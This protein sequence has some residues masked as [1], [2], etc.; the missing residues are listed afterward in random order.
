MGKIF[1]NKTTNTISINDAN[2]L[3]L[4]TTHTVALACTCATRSKRSRG[5]APTQIYNCL[6]RCAAQTKYSAPVLMCQRCVCMYVSVHHAVSVSHICHSH[7]VTSHQYTQPTYKHINGT[8]YQ[9]YLAL[10]SL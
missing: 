6:F 8:L 2:I 3:L 9:Y 1:Y 7:N 4:H 10:V 5:L